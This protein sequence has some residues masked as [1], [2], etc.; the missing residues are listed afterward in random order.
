MVLVD[1]TFGR[2]GIPAWNR[3]RLAAGCMHFKEDTMVDSFAVGA[4]NAKDPIYLYISITQHDV[5]WFFASGR[6][7]FCGT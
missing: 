3:R 1:G 6:S 5:T 2:F 7:M 4:N